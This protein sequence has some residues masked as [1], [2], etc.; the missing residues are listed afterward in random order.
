VPIERV[1]TIGADGHD[2]VVCCVGA[3]HDEHSWS[4]R[5]QGG[6]WQAAFTD[7]DRSD[8]RTA[9]DLL[10]TPDSARAALIASIILGPPKSMQDSSSL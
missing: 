5:G 2:A 7:A 9:L 1:H 8:V 3:Q 10:R 6:T 4:V